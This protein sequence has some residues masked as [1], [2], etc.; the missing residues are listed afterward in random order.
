MDKR[1]FLKNLSLVGLSA[2]FPFL[3]ALGNTLNSF[4][5]VPEAELAKNEEFWEA[6]RRGYLLNED[7]INLENGYY[8]MMPQETLLHYEE[9]VRKV[10]FLASR[11]MR[12]VQ[13]E[14]RQLARELLADMAGT[15]PDELI[16]TRNTTESLDLVIAGLDWKA[17]D[18]A[19]F[20]EQ[21]YGSMIDMFR[22]Q[23]ERHGIVT[24]M[25]SLPNHPKDDEEIVSLYRETDNG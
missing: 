7:Y 23:K 25:I 2:G 9:Q 15:S 10:N 24:R 4:K 6:I 20:A 1:S 3:E 21:D 12:T 17:G 13:F 16:I 22:V 18:E 19:V 11:Y 5:E 14:N 8:C